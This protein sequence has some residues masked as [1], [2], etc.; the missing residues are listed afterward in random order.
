MEGECFLT[1]LDAV[2][3]KALELTSYSGSRSMPA[4]VRAVDKVADLDLRS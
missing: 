2:T 3:D 1:S 4:K